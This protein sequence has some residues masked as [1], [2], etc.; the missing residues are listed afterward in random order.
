MRRLYF[1]VPS[2]DSAKQIVDERLLARIEERLFPIML[3]L[4]EFMNV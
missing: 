3:D 1:L 2:V 4:A